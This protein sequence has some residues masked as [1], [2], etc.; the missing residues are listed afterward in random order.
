MLHPYKSLEMKSL[1]AEEQD[2]FAKMQVQERNRKRRQRRRRV[3]MW[4]LRRL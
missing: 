2:V 4:I 3:L 1:Y